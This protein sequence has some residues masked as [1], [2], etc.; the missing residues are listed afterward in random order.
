MSKSATSCRMFFGTSGQAMLEALLKNKLNPE[1]IAQLVHYRLQPKIPRII[2]A[3]EGHRMSDHHR[4]LIRQSLDH[5]RYIETMIA[6]LD[7]AIGEKLRPY[8]KQIELACTVPGIGPG[9]A[10]SILAE[11][12]MDMNSDGPF[13]DCHHLASWAGICPGNNESAGKV[14]SGKTRKGNRW[15]RATLNQTAWAATA[16]KNSVFQIRFQ[17]LKVR[18]GAKRAV[19]AIAHAQ[20]IAVYW[21][22]RNGKPYQEHV[23]GPPKRCSLST[24]TSG[25]RTETTGILNPSSSPSACA[26]G[27]HGMNE[28]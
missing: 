20:L 11:T 5:M 16:K 10:A 17:K 14:K 1:E 2:E 18:R 6:E 8:E 24:T 15:L 9:G 7:T 19:T 22:L 27:I 21:T 23:L 3:L 25:S 13:P 12:G 28:T 4:M 26:V